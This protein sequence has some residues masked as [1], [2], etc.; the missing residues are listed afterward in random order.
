[1]GL[2]GPKI[3]EVILKMWILVRTEVDHRAWFRPETL[4]VFTEDSAP[5]WTEHGWCGWCGF[6]DCLSEQWWHSGSVDAA[7][8]WVLETDLDSEDIKNSQG[9]IPIHLNDK[10]ESHGR[11]RL[12]RVS[13]SAAESG[14]RPSV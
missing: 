14:E 3:Q 2:F 13:A 12:Q 1:M 9:L 7:L 10:N 5:R 11:H 6:A 8:T 4:L